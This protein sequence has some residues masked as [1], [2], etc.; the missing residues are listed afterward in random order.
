MARVGFLEVDCGMEMSHS[1]FVWIKTW[2]GKGEGAGGDGAA[3]RPSPLGR[4]G[5]YSDDGRP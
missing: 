1:M 5:R 3:T 2:E 4:G